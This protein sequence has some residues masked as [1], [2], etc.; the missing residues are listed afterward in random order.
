MEQEKKQQEPTIKVGGETF[1]LSESQTGKFGITKTEVQIILLLLLRQNRRG[2]CAQKV[3]FGRLLR[4]LRIRAS[5]DTR[6][7]LFKIYMENL[8]E[9]KDSGKVEFVSG[10]TR[11][12]IG[13]A[14]T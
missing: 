13:L 2:R 4:H 10:R 8:R 1:S 11:L 12:N 6:E 9:L 3:L 14:K 7:N 5:G